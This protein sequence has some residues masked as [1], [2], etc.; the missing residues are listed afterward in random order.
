M[1]IVVLEA[2]EWLHILRKLDKAAR[3]LKIIQSSFRI[4]CK[5]VGEVFI[6]KDLYAEI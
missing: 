5:L 4:N 2:L 1:H 3:R 6:K